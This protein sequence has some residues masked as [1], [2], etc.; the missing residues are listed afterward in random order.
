LSDVVES[1]GDEARIA[2]N[3]VGVYAGKT[4]AS[5]EA[6]LAM[7]GEASTAELRHWQ[8]LLAEFGRCGF[9]VPPA[10]AALSKLGKRLATRHVSKMTQLEKEVLLKKLEEDHRKGKP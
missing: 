3:V 1:G 9:E 10:T 8:E 6:V 5:V 4:V 7:P 2:R